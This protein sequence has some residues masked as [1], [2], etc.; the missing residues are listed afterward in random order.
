MDQRREFVLKA[1]YTSNFRQLC[2]E[3][4]ISPKTGYKWRERFHRHGLEGMGEESRRPKGHAK[5]LG[6]AV[7]CEIVRLK[8]AH[9][10]WG[11]R[12]LRDIYRRLHGP[13]P[14]ESS[15][16]RVL[17]R[18]GLVE[19]R[20]VRQRSQAGRIS[21]G[22]KASAANQIWTVDFKGWWYRA[23]KQRCEPLTVRDEWSRYVL[24][25]R[26]LADARTQTVRGCFERLFERHGVPEA[27]R[28]DNGVPFASTS[29]VLG[30]STLSAWW[31]ALGIDLERGRPGCPQDNGAHERLH[32]DVERELRGEE[33]QASFDQWRRSF[34]EERPHEALGMKRP[35]EVYQQSAR[36][37][38]GTPED[39]SYPKMEARRVKS[40]GEISYG[41][42]LVFI[43]TALAGWSVGLEACEHR[44]FNVHFGRLVLG[45]YDESAASFQRTE[46][47]PKGLDLSGSPQTPL[48]RPQT[49]TQAHDLSPELKLGRSAQV[50][51]TPLWDRR[52]AP[53]GGQEESKMCEPLT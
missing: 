27:I 29:G 22:R 51:A 28:S 48:R 10:W 11:P 53:F 52:R 33:Q 16:K 31:V 13:V 19:R 5:E 8:S 47:E 39:L 45:Q 14:S 1:L 25:V 21:T 37:Y 26:A 43:S 46:V 49:G 41:N 6:E 24:D 23:D 4:G 12:K 42:Q 2:Q 38:E 30:L 18:A 32:L 15:F 3:Y 50:G 9:R 35:A 7:I 40:T 17:E 20:R 34:N 44:K 36:K